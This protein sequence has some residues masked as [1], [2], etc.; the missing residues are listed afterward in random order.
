MKR[1]LLLL[2]LLFAVRPLHAF[3]PPLLSRA[4]AHR[5]LEAMAWTEITIVAIRQGVNP[6]GT[7]APIFATIIGFGKNAG[8]NR[9]FTECLY[10]DRE[11]DWHA[12]E[13]AERGARVWNKDG[14]R[15]IKPWAT[16]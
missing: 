1:A 9:G 10:Y 11:L 7:A 6:S 3:E 2:F 8:K 12:L 14:Y 13:L 16:W 5:I 15:E 4:D